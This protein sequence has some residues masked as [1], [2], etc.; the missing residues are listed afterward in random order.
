MEII[1]AFIVFFGGFTL[2]SISIEKEGAASKITKIDNNGSSK[3]IQHSSIPVTKLNDV[4]TC[5]I[6]HAPIYRDLTRPYRGESESQEEI[7][8]CE[9][10]D[11]DD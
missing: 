1:F 10:D 5:H 9:E 8:D 3:E 7:V 6:I 4:S 2:G 11:S